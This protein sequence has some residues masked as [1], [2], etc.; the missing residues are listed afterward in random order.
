MAVAEDLDPFQSGVRLENGTEI[1]V[2]QT[3]GCPGLSCNR[4]SA[5]NLVLLDLPVSDT[6]DHR[7]Q[8]DRLRSWESEVVRFLEA[9]LSVDRKGRGRACGP[10]LVAPLRVQ[11]FLLSVNP[12]GGSIGLAFGSIVFIPQL[13]CRSPA[14]SSQAISG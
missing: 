5:S 7:I 13:S 12:L 11:C 4:A 3:C 1:K 10:F 9:C 2:G 14:W 6:F 8:L